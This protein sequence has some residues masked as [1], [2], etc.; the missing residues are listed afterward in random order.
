MSEGP[1]Y[2]G[3]DPPGGPSTAPT[4][5]SRTSSAPRATSASARS[6]SRASARSTRCP[7]WPTPS[8]GRRASRSRRRGH[9]DLLPATGA[10][11]ARSCCATKKASCA[12]R[13]RAAS[14]RV[15]RADRRAL[16]L[17]RG[18]GRSGPVLVADVAAAGSTGA[19]GRGARRGNRRARVRPAPAQGRLLGKF[20]L[21]RT[22]HTS[23]T[24]ARSGSAARSRTNG[25]AT[26]RTRARCPP[27]AR[28][29]L[30][31]IMRTVDEGISPVDRRPPRLRERRLPRG[32]SA[33]SRR[34]NSSRTTVPHARPVRHA[35]RS[36]QQPHPGERPSR[37]ARSPG[38]GARK[39]VR[40]GFVRRA[41]S[42][43][44][45]RS[46]PVH[47]SD[48]SRSRCERYSRRHRNQTA[49][50]RVRSLRG[51]EMLN[52]TW[53]TSTRSVRSR[54]R[55]ADVRGPCDGGPRRGG[56]L[57]ASA[58]ATSIRRKPS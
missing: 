5:G 34:P 46:N 57:A 25:S 41:T 38:R 21:Y 18:R 33:S 19:R 36:R 49:D 31:T 24:S 4:G 12:S 43:D 6:S 3:R 8:P 26:V 44:R 55:G 28:E 40:T 48:G 58:H 29:Q 50:E 37:E 51:S 52:E 2:L 27:R 7:A 9:R 11:A 47:G 14:A 56:V 30:E 54:R 17:V 15:P 53:T 32:R 16:A 10:V 42:A 1:L 45:R 13:P 22:S 39:L 35:R 23:G 20:M